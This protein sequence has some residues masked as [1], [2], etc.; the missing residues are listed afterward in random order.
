MPKAAISMAT[1]N[2]HPGNHSGTGSDSHV[3]GRHFFFFPVGG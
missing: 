3:T 2:K 1:N